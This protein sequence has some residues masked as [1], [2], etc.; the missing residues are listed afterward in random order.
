MLRLPPC[1]STVP[2]P[3]TNRKLTESGRRVLA[4]AYRRCED[5]VAVHSGS[6][7]PPREW[8]ERD[9]LFGG[10]VAFECMTRADSPMVVRALLES[11]HRVAM[12]TGDAPLTALHVARRVGM[13][14]VLG[15]AGDDGASAAAGGV[16]GAMDPDR[17]PLLLTVSS[18]DGRDVVEWVAALT[19]NR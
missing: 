16:D 8:V 3:A 17:A 2:V 5:G 1:L 11:C 9:L 13:C 4:L 14:P 15:S 7:A 6:T 19:G 12:V 18:V 10:F